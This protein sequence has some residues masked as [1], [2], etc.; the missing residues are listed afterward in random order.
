[1]N[2]LGHLHDVRIEFS[3]RI[4]I[5]HHHRGH[6]VVQMRLQVLQVG[7]SVRQRFDIDHPRPAHGARGWIRAVRRVG[8][9]HDSPFGL[10]MILEV[11]ANHFQRCPLAVRPGRRLKRDFIEPRNLLQKQPQLIEQSQ[12]PLRLLFRLH[13]MQIGKTAK[14]RRPLVHLRVVLH[15]AR[16]ERIKIGVDGKRAMRQ[17]RVMPHQLELPNLRQARLDKRRQRRIQLHLRHI[18]FRQIDGA[19]AWRGDFKEKFFFGVDH[20]RFQ[21]LTAYSKDLGFSI[22][23]EAS[24]ISIPTTFP[25]LP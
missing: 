21:A 12:R 7:Q 19:C 11:S 2:Q 6:F 1:M 10:S 4:W 5:G 25:F 23:V 16:A 24:S 18:R 17:M 15:R 14:R 9:E 3:D 20:R 13:R 8:R 22:C